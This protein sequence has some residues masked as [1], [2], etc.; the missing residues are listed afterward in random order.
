M[1][2]GTNR[3]NLTP[4]QRAELGALAQTWRKE[5]T[6]GIVV[7]V[8]AG[9]LNARAAADIQREVRAILTA[10]GVPAHSIAVRPYQPE[11]PAKLATI[12]VS[13]PRMTAETGPCGLWPHDIG[14]SWDRAYNENRPYWN[15]GCAT[16]RNL[17]VMVA[18]PAD[19]EQPREEAPVYAGRRTTVLEKYRKG[20]STAT[21]YP[22]DKKGKISDVG[23]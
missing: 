9:T 3:G 1:F 4:T 11:N 7:S 21:T 2:I 23:Q 12:K 18:N 8:P 22:D 20:E 10:G 5:A 15:F 16:Q 6:G 14:P 17:A 13:Y 19:L